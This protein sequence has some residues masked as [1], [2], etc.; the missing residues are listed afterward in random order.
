MKLR[1]AI[2]LLVAAALLLAGCGS[3]PS[4][5]SEEPYS[6]VP[7]VSDPPIIL[8]KA[9]QVVPELL[10][11]KVEEQ[12]DRKYGQDDYADRIVF[13]FSNGLPEMQPGYTTKP[14]KLIAEHKPH[15]SYLTILFA[16]VRIKGD[17][18]ANKQIHRSPK[19]LGLQKNANLYEY[20]YTADERQPNTHVEFQA[21]YLFKPVANVLRKVYVT[22]ATVTQDGKPTT[23]NIIVTV[24]REEDEK[25]YLSEDDS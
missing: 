10:N 20:A 2:L 12:R 22:H 11:V 16:G 14:P 21:A 8:G 5:K 6:G 18:P 23:Y 15:S 13:T 3:Y 9:S 17:G 19:P 1:N 4:A 25:D 7:D 24:S